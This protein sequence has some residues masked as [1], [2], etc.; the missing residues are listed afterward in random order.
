M[1]GRHEH[2][3][4]IV[5]LGDTDVLIGKCRNAPEL[6]N[7]KMHLSVGTSDI[8]VFPATET[9]TTFIEASKA[10]A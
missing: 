1:R 8:M 3:I 7:D 10:N 6:Q 4:P 5:I 9:N 2:L